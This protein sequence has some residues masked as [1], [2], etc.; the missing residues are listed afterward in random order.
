MTGAML[1]VMRGVVSP[2]CWPSLPSACVPCLSLYRSAPG[3]AAFLLPGG[4]PEA[5]LSEP[6]TMDIILKKRLGFC[7][8][9]LESGEGRR[10]A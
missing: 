2:V 8:V 9:A 5:L 3:N 4:A 6:G 10:L 7:R 1:S